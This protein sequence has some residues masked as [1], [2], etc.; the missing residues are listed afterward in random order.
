ML[1]LVFGRE[2]VFSFAF[3]V[4]LIQ[5]PGVLEL[6]ARNKDTQLAPNGQTWHHRH[7]VT[8]LKDY[9]HAIL[10]KGLL[11]EHSDWIASL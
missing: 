7:E 1:H 5:G 10:F 6:M 3:E 8:A 11:N 2:V 4:C 9:R